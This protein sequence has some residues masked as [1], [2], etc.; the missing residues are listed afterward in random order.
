MKK[1][2]ENRD[3]IKHIQCSLRTIEKVAYQTYRLSFVSEHLARCAR[4]GQF[5]HVN[6]GGG[7]SLR[8]PF[9][10]HKIK[11]NEVFLLFRVVGRGTRR[12]KEYHRGDTLDILGPLGNGFRFHEAHKYSHVFLVAGGMGVAPLV[13]LSQKIAQGTGRSLVDAH[14]CVGVKTK[15]DL[16][17]KSD[18]PRQ[19]KIYTAS[20]DGTIGIK[21]SVID[22]LEKKLIQVKDKNP[23]IK[24]YAC[25]PKPMFAEC[26]RLLKQYPFCDCEVSFEQFMGCGIGVCL[27]CVIDTHDGYKRVCKDGPVFDLKSIF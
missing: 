11:G 4:P 22:A 12:L 21:G 18:F 9:S 14:V 6:V 25:G 5:V 10:I 26:A 2:T 17:A 24:I 20:D 13:F 16:I 1:K 7:L 19:F 3:A 27:G 15:K 23:R 8:R